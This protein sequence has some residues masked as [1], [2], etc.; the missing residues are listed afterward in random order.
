VTILGQLAL[1]LALLMAAW[2]SVIGILGGLQRRPELIQSARR[3]S[4]ALLGILSVASIALLVALLRH[5]FNVQYVWAYTSRN[6]P[7]PYV[8]SAG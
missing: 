4:Y 3:T 2:G 8:I 5:D 6:L 1:W 7:T